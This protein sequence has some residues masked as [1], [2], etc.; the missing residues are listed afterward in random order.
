MADLTPV[1][2]GSV[3]GCV[4]T[5]PMTLAMEAMHRR[6][7]S[8][9]Q[10]P[11]PP[12]QITDNLAQHVGMNPCLDEQSRTQTAL[13]AHFAFGAAMGA[14]YGGLGSRLP[15]PEPARGVLLGV[16]VWAGNYLGFLPSVGLLS[17]ATQ[18]PLRRSALMITAH[19]VWGVTTGLLLNA[20][21][22]NSIPRNKTRA[23]SVVMRRERA[24]ELPPGVAAR[25]QLKQARGTST[26]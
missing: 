11:L 6:L 20:A 16:G 7:P 8:D 5:L 18:H 23:D 1:I 3:A 13:V 4:A 10:Y 2:A 22:R 19:V 17:P 24:R 15:V 9:E 25:A 12:Q 26:R 21:T 14:L